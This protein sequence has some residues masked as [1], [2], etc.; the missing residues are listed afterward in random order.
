[1]VPIITAC[2]VGFALLVWHLQNRRHPGWRASSDGRFNIYCGYPLVLIAVYWLQ[3]AP[4]ATAWEWA[5]GNVWALGA[6]VA[7]VS[8]FDLLNRA[9]A[10]HAVLAQAAE[11]VTPAE[12]ALPPRV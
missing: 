12:G 3:T 1:M 10:Q 9:T 4:T 7:F 6:M 5:V 11:T 2:V 8:G